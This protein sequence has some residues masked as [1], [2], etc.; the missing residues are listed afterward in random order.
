[1][2]LAGTT[3]NFAMTS[4]CVQEPRRNGA[5]PNEEHARDRD[6][7]RRDDDGVSYASLRSRPAAESPAPNNSAGSAHAP[8]DPSVQSSRTASTR[9]SPGPSPH[10]GRNARGKTF[11]SPELYTCKIRDT[12]SATEWYESYGTGPRK[13]P[14]APIRKLVRNP[15]LAGFRGSGG[16]HVLS[17]RLHI[18]RHGER[19]QAWMWT[20]MSKRLPRSEEA[21]GAEG[22]NGWVRAFEGMEHPRLKG[23]VLHF[24]ENGEP[25]WVRETSA[26]QYAA[27]RRR[28]TSFEED[29][30][31]SAT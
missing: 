31:M 27:G 9:I 25:R 22:T 15:E 16:P 20:G 12:K 28:R 10:A 6:A 13:A 7:A 29:V 5:S 2:T 23:Y 30:E 17:G 4:A 19:L 14:P 21:T 11:W 1:M 26:K 8:R 24:I 18:H 3:S